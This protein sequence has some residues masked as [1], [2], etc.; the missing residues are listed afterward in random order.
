[1][2][3]SVEKLINGILNR[4]GDKYTDNPSDS[5][6]ATKW[7][8][9]QATLSKVRG[10]PVTKDEVKALTRAEAYQIYYD[11][12]YAQPGFE[13]VA[14]TS[15]AVADKL[16]DVQVNLP[17]GKA[18]SF[19][20][21]L[22][23]GLNLNGTKYGD[24]EVDGMCGPGVRAALTK[25]LAWRGAEGEQVLL[26]GIAHL[27]GEYYVDR[28]EKRPANEEFLYGWLLNRAQARPA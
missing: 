11:I 1:M 14:A 15:Q 19:M 13:K 23:N 18:T 27:Q 24:L 12:F 5:G 22:L 20:Q 21:R 9:T 10:R 2:S 8:I 16:T 26:E 4:E 3:S 25:Y 17:Y 6:G 28:A 7:G